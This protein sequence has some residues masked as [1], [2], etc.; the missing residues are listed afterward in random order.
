MNPG[1]TDA[2]DIIVYIRR[3]GV[4]RS[5]QNDLIDQHT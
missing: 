2:K 5:L 1:T 4:C 3:I